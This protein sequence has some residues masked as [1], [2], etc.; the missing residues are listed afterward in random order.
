[1]NFYNSG[2]VLRYCPF[3][4]VRYLNFCSILGYWGI[5][6]SFS[7]SR[8]L[9]FFRGYGAGL[10]LWLILGQFILYYT[11]IDLNGLNIKGDGARRNKII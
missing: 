11:K 4:K 7:S 2:S 8:F 6:G 10:D 1:M 5:L 3:E 9:K